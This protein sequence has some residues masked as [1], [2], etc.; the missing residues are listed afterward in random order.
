MVFKETVNVQCQRGK[1]RELHLVGKPFQVVLSFDNYL[2]AL[3][4]KHCHMVV[5]KK[6][7]PS[8]IKVPSTREAKHQL[9]MKK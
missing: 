5:N 2:L 1:K 6:G 8:P 3:C 9:K 7:D 4:A